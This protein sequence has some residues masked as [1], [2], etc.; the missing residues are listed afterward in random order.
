V[1]ASLLQPGVNPISAIRNPNASKPYN[2]I[3]VR[4]YILFFGVFIQIT[5]N[6]ATSYEICFLVQTF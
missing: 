3:F 1:G 2:L 5:E 4:T 6:Q